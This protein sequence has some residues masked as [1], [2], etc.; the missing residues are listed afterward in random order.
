[1]SFSWILHFT[2]GTLLLPCFLALGSSLPELKK[3]QY[4]SKEVDWNQS[5]Q[6]SVVIHASLEDVWNYASDSTKAQDWSI[7]FDHITP[8]PG[9]EDGKVGSLRRCFRNFD[10]RGERWDEMTI[11]VI[12]QA[13]R[14]LVTFN[15]VGFGLKFLVKNQF[16]FVRQIFRRIDPFTTELTFQTQ[17]SHGTALKGKLAFL[18]S[19]KKSLKTF[20]KNLQNIKADIEG[21]PRLYSWE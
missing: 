3:L 17:L 6:A 18:L 13:S 8:L 2:L 11:E 20:E 15:L 14:T 7:F 12:P 4:E 16:I 5:V 10:E 19:R 21:I 1:M 9:V